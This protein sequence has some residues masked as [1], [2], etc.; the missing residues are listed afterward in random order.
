MRFSTVTSAA[1]LSAA[2]A[3]VLGKEMPVD[4]ERAARESSRAPRLILIMTDM[5]S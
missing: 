3:P 4:E 1:V 5:F 2:I